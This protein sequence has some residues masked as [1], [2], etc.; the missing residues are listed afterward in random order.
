MNIDVTI[1]I[2]IISVVFAVCIGT[3]NFLRNKT[4]DDRA[5]ASE[6]VK[7]SVKLDNISIDISDIKAEMRTMKNDN[8]EDRE[9]IVKVEESSKQAHK[10]LDSLE[11]QFKKET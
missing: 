2:S 5:E 1:L 10:R 11:K 3:T 6:I 8:K 7:V 9:R 4:K